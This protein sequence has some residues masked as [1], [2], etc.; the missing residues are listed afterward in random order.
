VIRII[1]Q[2]KDVNQAKEKL[3]KNFKLTPIQAQ[4]ILE[5]QLQRLTSLERKKLNNEY[6]ELIKKIEF[7]QSI[8]ASEV[9]VLDVIKEEAQA[10]KNKYADE[11]RSEIVRETEELEIEDLI[12]EEDMVITLSHQG[13]IKR[14]PVS[15][16]R[17][18]KRGGKGTTGMK[19]KEE[20]FVEHLFIAS[21]HDHLLFLTNVGKLY[22]L[23]VHE[24][25]QAS[26]AAK[27]R[28]VVNLLNLA[29]EEQVSS[30]IPKRF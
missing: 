9:K 16:Y 15:S 2:S 4:A 8:L 17:R 12:A 27:G 3:I 24:I 14:L 1:R 13:Y 29:S 23:K 26:R 6:L 7:Y 21:T 19:T 20:D 11:R 30:C 5:M 22:W 25:P 28:P 18:Q 10:V